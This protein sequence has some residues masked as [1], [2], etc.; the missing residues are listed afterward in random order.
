MK[1]VHITAGAGGRICGSCLH[2]NALVRALRARG[3][4]AILVPAYVPTTTDEENVA[5]DHVVMGGVNVWLQEHVPLFRY[6]PSFVDRPLDSRKL[7]GWLSSRTGSAKP[8]DLG[9]L[10][11]STLEGEH[12]RQRKEVRKLGR[13]LAREQRPD[14]VHLSNA[15][16]IGLAK[17]IRDATGARIVASLSGEDVFIDGLPEPFR[18]RVWELLR[19]RAADVDHFIAFNRFFADFMRDRMQLAADTLSVVPHGV[20]LAQ[21]P[22]EPP[23]LVAR[24]KA[25]GGMFNVGFLARACPEKGLEVLIRALATL[26]RDRDV[27][28]IAAG[29][30]VEAERDYL[31]RCLALAA[32]LGVR[33]RFSWRGQVDRAGKLA[34][35][36]DIDLFALPTTHP[37]AKGLSA[38]EAMAAG[39]PVVAANHGAFPEML[40]DE[41][42]GLLHAPGDPSDLARVLRRLVDDDARAAACGQH[43]HALARRRH[44]SDA[45]ATG[46]EAIYERLIANC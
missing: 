21:F 12:G 29:A 26:A 46:H 6:T 1:I 4:D 33:D 5:I 41:Q 31:A 35:L 40:D 8:A 18:S 37:E 44:S 27:Q 36:R 16:L 34:L 38:I 32:E 23:D 15:L 30:T 19:T 7:L 42:A 13:W 22:A 10:T 24:R 17:E 11:V 14:I 3:R 25:R 20:D 2:D 45:M 28:V 39:V 9:P 43:A